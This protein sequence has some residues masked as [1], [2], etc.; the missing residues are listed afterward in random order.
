[1]ARV[2][3]SKVSCPLAFGSRKNRC[4]ICLANGLGCWAGLDCLQDE[5]WNQGSEFRAPRQKKPAGKVCSCPVGRSRAEGQ[6]VQAFQRA[7]GAT[8]GIL[9]CTITGMLAGHPFP[10]RGLLFA[11]VKQ[12]TEGRHCHGRPRMDQHAGIG[13]VYC[14]S[15]NVNCH[16]HFAIP[17]SMA[18]GV[19]Q[20]QQEQSSDMQCH[21]GTT[22]GARHTASSCIL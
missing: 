21:S 12:S 4:I 9:R 18:A 2:P 15:I 1:M 22:T 5:L 10:I 19:G 13:S 14:I 6:R 17:H 3:Y 16:C 20:A 8:P 7:R 11:Q